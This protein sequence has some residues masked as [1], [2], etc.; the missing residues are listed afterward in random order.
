MSTV[1]VGCKLPSGLIIE[2]DEQRV[3][4]NGANSSALVGG[5]GMTEV[6]KALFDAWLAKHKDYEPVKQ[7]LVFA[8]EKPVN[9]QAEA[10]DKAELKNGFEGIDPKKPAKGIAPMD[11]KE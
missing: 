8:Q 6:N 7:G 9:A 11:T 2:L 4:L 3:V 1:T 5:F 10:K